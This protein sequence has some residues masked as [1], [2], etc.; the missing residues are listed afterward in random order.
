MLATRSSRSLRSYEQNR[1][2]QGLGFRALGGHCRSAP[3]QNGDAPQGVLPQHK[4]NMWST[5]RRVPFRD[6][7]PPRTLRKKYTSPKKTNLEAIGLVECAKLLSKTLRAARCTT[8]RKQQ[9]AHTLPSHT[10][11]RYVPPFFMAACYSRASPRS[12]QTERCIRP[13]PVLREHNLGRTNSGV[14]GFIG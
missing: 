4:Q 5:R 13:T 9:K 8:S 2:I 6:G 1:G 3:H 11:D 10:Y 12:S 7:I 14:S